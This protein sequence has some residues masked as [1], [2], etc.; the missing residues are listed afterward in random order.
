MVQPRSHGASPNAHLLIGE[1]P[2]PPLFQGHWWGGTGLSIAAHAIAAAALLYAATHVPQVI[3]TAATASE[4]FNKIVFLNR[5]GPGGGGGG[6]GTNAPDPPRQREITPAKPIELSP[7]VNPADTPPVPE[8]K[9]PVIT[10]QAQQMLPGADAPID[11]TAPGRGADPGGGAGRGPGSGPGEGSG[12]GPGRLAGFGGDVFGPG[13][14]ATQPV[15]IREVKP[16]YTAQAM[17][18]KL[19]GRVEMD[20]VV[21]ADG[22]VDAASIRIT[23]SLDSTFGLDQQAIIAVKQWRFRPGTFKG[24]PVAVRVG[25]ELTF[26][27]R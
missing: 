10:V 9:I 20:A 4:R 23:R 7:L 2:A 1:M 8:L 6:G 15:L 17:S 27:L 18:A 25:V 21:L 24:Q 12:L 14:G 19:Q 13:D 5:P 26:T 16:H 22:S 11:T 3:Q